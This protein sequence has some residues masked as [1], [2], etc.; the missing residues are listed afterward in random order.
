MGYHLTILR[1]DKG[2]SVPI[3]EDEF[4]NAV[5]R[6]TTLQLDKARLSARYIKDGELRS[7]IT[8]TEGQ[9]WTNTA[10][11]DVLSIM[12]ELAALL[13]AR[14]RG[15]EGESYRSPQET[16]T[17][18]DDIADAEIGENERTNRKHRRLFWNVV[19]LLAVLVVLGLIVANA[20]RK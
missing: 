8:L 15:D 1:T 2:T 11:E 10:E 3:T 18:P 16:Y 19:R 13:K 20:L 6:I 4:A 7:T 12:V 14:V 17:H 9:V 5:P